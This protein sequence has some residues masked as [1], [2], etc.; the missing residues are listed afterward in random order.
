VTQT[1]I[2]SGFA[3]SR[4]EA[5]HPRLFPDAG[6]W[7]PSLQSPGG[8]RLHDLRGGN[9]GTLTN[10]DPASDWVVNGGRLA[11]DFD[12]S[13][14]FVVA[15]T[16][17]LSGSLSF[18][19]WARG[20]PGNASTNYIAS[21]PIASSGS[22]GIDFRNPTNAQANLALS[23][24]F[25]SINSGVDIRGSWS[26][27][28]CGYGNGVAFFYVNGILVGS[29][30]WANG[31]N[32]LSSREL[33]LGRFGSFGSHSPV[34]LDDIRI[35]RTTL[36]AADIRQLW[37]LGRGNMPMIRKRRYTEETAATTNRRRRLI[38]GSNC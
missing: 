6:W 7:C 21:I 30:A 13:N 26:H 17:L 11:L 5:L 24:T 18:S 29:Q 8:T 12:G 22:N 16:P 20:V 27:L 36:N 1:T 25:V 15:T 28:L 19:V 37:Q 35:F 32:S 38:C 9:W 23:G 2:Q 33:N 31:L 10:M 4:S 34:Q 14:D 3:R